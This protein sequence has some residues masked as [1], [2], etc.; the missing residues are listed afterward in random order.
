MAKHQIDIINTTSDLTWDFR[1]KTVDGIE[2]VLD[3][4][5]W[6]PISDLASMVSGKG[7]SLIGIQD[8]GGLFL[9]ADVEEALQELKDL[10]DSNAAGVGARWSMVD[11]AVAPA[12]LPAHS[13]DGAGAGKTLTGDANG[14]LTLQSYV[15]QIGDRVL[16]AATDADGIGLPYADHGIYIVTDNGSNDDPFVLT[17]AADADGQSDFVQNKTVFVESGTFAGSTFSL[18]T[19]DVVV[20]SSAIVFNKIATSAIP[21]ASIS[22]AKLAALSVTNSKL[23]ADSV[24]SMKIQDGAVLDAKI[25]AM[26]ASKLT[27]SVEDDNIS[28]SSVSQHEGDLTI[29]ESQIS[30][31]KTYAL[32]SGLDVEANAI[33]ALELLSGAPG[34]TDMGSFSG[35]TIAD[36]SSMKQALQS[37]ETSLENK[38]NI[39]DHNSNENLITALTQLTGAGAGAVDM[40]AWVNNSLPASADMKAVFEEIGRRTDIGTVNFQALQTAVGAEASSVD[41]TMLDVAMASSSGFIYKRPEDFE[42]G[43]SLFDEWGIVQVRIDLTDFEFEMTFENT[44]KKN[45]FLASASS[46]T[47]EGQTVEVVDAV[48]FSFDMIKWASYDSIQLFSAANAATTWDITVSDASSGTDL[49]SFSGSTIADDSTVKVALQALETSLETKASDSDLSVAEG[50]LDA[51]DIAFQGVERFKY[52]TVSYNAAGGFVDICDI[53]AGAQILEVRAK[54]KTA[55]DG[56][57]PQ[58]SVGHTGDQSAL[59]GLPEFEA[60]DAT[61]GAN[62]QTLATWYENGPAQTFRA[63]LNLTGATQGEALVGIRYVG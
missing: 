46:V 63:Y 58:F 52:A 61:P 36:D 15:W 8:A 10:A 60:A 50:R 49:G 55:F 12:T 21:N 11:L 22:T 28:S 25:A 35:S 62:P 39:A 34:D 27:G 48:D 56:V 4:S 31:F 45:V 5:N 32:Q 13:S 1:S 3:P 20:D 16:I 26:S 53:P 24:S 44:T 51:A 54:V 47:V 19:A 57:T 14:A 7:A 2:V 18:G 59:A 43:D 33:S 30:D 41:T 23:D 42:A 29:S 17:R 38:S 40:G 37:L 6:M 9:A